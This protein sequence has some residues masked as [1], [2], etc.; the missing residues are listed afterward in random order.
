LLVILAKPLDGRLYTGKKPN[1]AEV[2]TPS[3]VTRYSLPDDESSW[4]GEA[5]VLS[6][7]RQVGKIIPIDGCTL[8]NFA[9]AKHRVLVA[10]NSFSMSFVEAFDQLVSSDKYAVTITSSAGASPVAGIPG[11]GRWDQA[12]NY[13]WSAVVPSLISHLRSGDSV[14]LA[15]DLAELSPEKASD[16]S[17]RALSQLSE[18]LVNLSSHLS[19]RGIRL[20][21]LDGLPFARDADCEPAAAERQ[22]FAPFGGPCHFLLKRR[23]LLRRAKL[24]ESL[25]TLRNEGKISIVDLMDVF[26]PG[27][28]CTYDS[29]TGQ[30]LYRD[31]WSHP[32]VEA[33]RLSA[34]LIRRVLTSGNGS[35]RSQ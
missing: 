11:S 35:A 25:N 21:V 23:T 31:V 18:G 5:C 8:G 2:G 26:C 34:P 6:D 13:Y 20:V 30:M 7:N 17:E 15:S 9:T 16:V 10:G 1:L 3:L 4:H 14:F 19:E 32:S 28:M 24:D 27:T 12:S 22:W 29:R 33:A